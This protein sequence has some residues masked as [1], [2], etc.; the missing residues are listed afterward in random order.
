M[1]N[2]EIIDNAKSEIGKKRTALLSITKD[3][4]KIKIFNDICDKALSKI[5]EYDSLTS[6]DELTK[7]NDKEIFNMGY[8]DI[9][10]ISVNIDKLL[11]NVDS[12]FSA[13]A[14]DSFV[15][16]KYESSNS[17]PEINENI[18]DKENAENESLKERLLNIE[19]KNNQLSH[20]AKN[21]QII[22]WDFANNFSIE[23]GPMVI[24]ENIILQYTDIDKEI[25]KIHDSYKFLSSE[26]NKITLYELL[27]KTYRL[28]VTKGISE[29]NKNHLKKIT[30]ANI[31]KYIKNID[32][33][34]KNNVE[35]DNSF[36]MHV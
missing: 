20:I 11:E 3:N 6:V 7:S 9:G 28:D 27:K 30:R 12:N 18:I 26:K 25:T 16:D 32:E 35:I 34:I 8:S 5:D 19:L 24:N 14:Y 21:K 31:L 10:N 1:T 33:I 36:K 4:N 22:G 17:K 2:K 13:I 29:Q 15:N 23:R